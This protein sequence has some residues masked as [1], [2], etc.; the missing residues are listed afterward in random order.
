MRWSEVSLVPQS[1]L[2]AMNPVLTVGEHVVDTLL[3]HSGPARAQARARGAELLERV[4]IAPV[5]LDSYPH[6][7]SGGMR[8]RVALA[9]ALALDP[10]LIV[11]DEPT[12]A[13]DVVVEREIL[14]QILEL[15]A[16]RRFAMIF[17]THDVSLL[18]ELAT[19]VAVMYAGRLVEV[20]P[21]EAYR[22]GARHPYTR[23]LLGAIAPAIDEDREPV[24]IPGSP[25]S[26]ARPP[27][28]CP[29]HPRCALA[30]PACAV[31]EPALRAVGA[32]HEVACP[33]V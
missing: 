12:T 14:A 17:I 7:L 1:A 18:L 4:G 32:G 22:A 19:R 24:S 33:R 16:A 3:A 30:V 2:S 5:H 29:F 15:Q 9:L 10:A 11:M 21:V 8:Q 20:G 13:L 26:A 27:P 28:G 31:D 23:G 6:Q 25:P